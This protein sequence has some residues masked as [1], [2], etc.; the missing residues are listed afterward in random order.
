MEEWEIILLNEYLDKHFPAQAIDK[1]LK[2]GTPLSGPKGLR[3]QLAELDMEYFARAYFPERLFRDMPEFHSQGYRDLQQI[4]DNPGGNKRA[5]AAPRGYSKSTRTTLIFPLYCT[6]YRKKKYIFIISDTAN[7]SS[8]FLQDIQHE[9]ESNERILQDFGDLAGQPWNTN[10]CITKTG[11]KLECAGSGQ[12]IRGRRHGAYRPDL[13]VL[14]DLENDENTATPEQRAKLKNW[15]TKVVLKIGDSYTDFVYVGTIIHYDSLFSWALTNPIWQPVVYRAVISFATSCDLWDEWESILTD[16]SKPKRQ[17]DALAF[18]NA[19]KQDM[20]SGTEVLWPE[21]QNYY[22]LMLVR[23][24]EGEASFNS[25]L[26]NEPI[27]PEDRLFS[28]KFYDTLPPREEMRVVAA[29][30]PSMGKTAQSDFTAIIVV[31]KHLKTGYLY[32][33]DAVLK[34]MHPDKIIETLFDLHNFWRL[35]E[36]CV[37]TVQFQQFFKDEIAKRSARAGIYLNL[38]EVK[39][40][41][42]KELRIQSIQP[43]IN[44]GYVKFSKSQRL[45]V[46]QLENWPKAAHDDGPD[47]LEMVISALLGSCSMLIYGA[48]SD[49]E[50]TFNDETMPAGLKY[51][52]SRSIAVDYGT[53]N[54][55]VF[56][57]LWDDGETIWQVNE[58]H[59]DSHEIGIQKTDA[60]YADDLEQ[61]IGDADGDEIPDE[62]ILDAEVAA[63][64]KSELRQRGFRVKDANTDLDSGIRIT[65]TMINRRLYR[66][67][68]R[69]K[70]TIN[71]ILFYRWDEKSRESGKEEPI[72]INDDTVTA[73]RFF[74][75]TR[76]KPWRLT[77]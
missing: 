3:K 68:E 2:E 42:N 12:K 4:A 72:G 26:Q 56:L 13:V 23:V 44:N 24:T 16:M 71:E 65:A 49:K 43:T 69:C 17:A 64:F 46:E 54:P 60:Q 66:V 28:C 19:N 25:E 59:Y 11:I 33:I 51:T 61:F 50:N 67:H 63:S 37:E 40:I 52:A 41:K 21:K 31:G 34:R 8:E 32:I 45:L 57:D 70:N 55:M 76:I 1:L 9:L 5:E 36:T 38:R 10:E 47:A 35:D 27:N 53:T 29:V 75:K 30:D 39:S 6:L 22:D 20:L 74:M 73:I 14:D 15:F 7:Q 77:A 18:F 58:Y 48:W 62:I